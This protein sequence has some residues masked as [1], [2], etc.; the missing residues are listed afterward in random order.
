MGHACR[1][2]LWLFDYHPAKRAGWVAYYLPAFE[3]FFHIMDF[4][5]GGYLALI[6]LSAACAAM[7]PARSR[8]KSAGQI[9][10]RPNDQAS[11]APT[12]LTRLRW[13]I[14]AFAPSSLLLGVTTHL[15][16]N[17]AAAPLFWVVP[18]VLYLLSFIIAFQRLLIIPERAIAFL[19]AIRC[20]SVSQF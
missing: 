11:V 12:N 17:I 3:S 19:Q 9:T 20:C 4:W 10:Q 2:L 14:L 13:L 8:S 1:H 15:T 5:A 16:T 18:L 6:V 7:V